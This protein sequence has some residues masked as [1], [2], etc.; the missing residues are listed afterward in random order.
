[1]TDADVAASRLE[2]LAQRDVPIGPLTTYRV[3]GTASLF[4][5]VETDDDLGRVAAA[6]RE[7]GVRVL[8]VGNGSNLLVSEA[9]FAGLAVVLGDTYAS[10]EIVRP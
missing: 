8:V 2:G 5:R 9:G 1:M 7:S 3:G 6:V 10:I 4:V